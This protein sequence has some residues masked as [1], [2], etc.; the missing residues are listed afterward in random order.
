MCITINFVT[1]CGVTKR[2]ILWIHCF[3]I[4]C[5]KKKRFAFNSSRWSNVGK[6]HTEEGRKY[7]TKYHRHK[8]IRGVCQYKFVKIPLLLLKKTLQYKPLTLPCNLFS[9]KV[10][11]IIFFDWIASIMPHIYPVGHCQKLVMMTLI[12][13]N[14]QFSFKNTLLI[15]DGKL[16]VTFKLTEES[17]QLPSRQRMDSDC[18]HFECIIV[19]LRWSLM[20]AD[21]WLS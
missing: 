13:L 17:A 1:H 15:H 18:R 14:I 21:L 10:W 3:E 5:K 19:L 6:E 12:T 9:Q 16:T 2:Q 8:K 4:T 7:S 11:K 20:T